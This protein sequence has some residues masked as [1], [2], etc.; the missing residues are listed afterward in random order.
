MAV[1]GSC[2]GVYVIL[3]MAFHWFVEPTVAKSREVAAYQPPPATVMQY[4]A[5]PVAVPVAPPEPPSRFAATSAT[6]APTSAAPE[7]ADKPV[8]TTPKKP[9]RQR[10]ERTTARHERPTN[11]WNQVGSASGW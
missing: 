8:D 2:L 1:V 6:S 11:G 4:T 10:A 9:S 5:A 7:P 3:A